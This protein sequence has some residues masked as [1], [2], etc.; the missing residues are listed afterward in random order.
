MSDDVIDKREEL[1]IAC[2][3]GNKDLFIKCSSILKSEYFEPPLDNVVQFILDYFNGYHGIPSPQIVEAETDIYIE[4]EAVEL[5]SEFNYVI[6]TIEEHCQYMA[7]REAVLDGADELSK[8]NP[9]KGKIQNAVRDALLISIDKDIGID[10]FRDPLQRLMKMQENIDARSIGW[11]SVDQIIEM[12]KRGELILF[13]GNSG[14]GKSVFLANIFHNMAS[15]GLNCL[16]ISLELGEE[17]VAK[18]VDSL[19]TDV[20]ISSVFDNVEDVVKLLG[21]REEGYGSMTVKRMPARSTNVNHIRAYL[22]EYELEYGYKPDVICVDYLDLLE[23]VERIQGN[24]FDIDKVKSEELRELFQ[25]YHAYGFT[26]SQ[27]NRGAVNT[28]EKDQSD[29]AGGLSKINTCDVGFAITRDE[30][31]KDNGEVWLYPIKLRNSPGSNNPIVLY[32]DDKTARI[33]DKHKKSIGVKAGG[34]GKES[35]DERLKRLM[36]KGAKV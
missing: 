33:T 18:R 13:A 8:D 20:P 24:A 16:M 2:L 34:K 28:Q 23:T 26:A 25:E 31:Q 1:M 3:L 11:I 29:I 14:A 15:D 5:E 32:W 22:T 21:D 10:Q 6:E 19:I 35:A 17:L 36:H 4:P 7:L 9:D 12:V 27:L 30:V